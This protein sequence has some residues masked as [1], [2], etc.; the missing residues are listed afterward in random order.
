MRELG[1]CP[2]IHMRRSRRVRSKADSQTAQFAALHFIHLAAIAVAVS[3]S[4]S[5]LAGREG[6]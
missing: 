3:R 6:I 2:G 4:A 1:L 5:T